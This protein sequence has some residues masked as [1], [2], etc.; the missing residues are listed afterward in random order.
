MDL[1]KILKLTYIELFSSHT[2]V[3]KN[4]LFRVLRI[5]DVCSNT[6]FYVL[7]VSDKQSK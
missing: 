6:N 2:K 1:L 3:T 7:Y 4:V 5:L